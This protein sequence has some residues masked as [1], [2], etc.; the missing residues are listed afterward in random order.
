M[1]PE[2]PICNRCGVAVHARGYLLTIRRQGSEG[3]T[4]P[5]GPLCLC[6][7]YLTGMLTWL[8]FDAE[9]EV[10]TVPPGPLVLE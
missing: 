2:L 5:D 6:G 7:R 4:P 3:P 10:F 1:S 8:G 9:E